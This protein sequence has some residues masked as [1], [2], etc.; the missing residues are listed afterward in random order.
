MSGAALIGGGL[1]LFGILWLLK[2]LMSKMRQA[3]VAVLDQ[4]DKALEQDQKGSEQKVVELKKA[5]AEKEKD[6]EKQSEPGQVID[7]WKG[8]QAQAQGSAPASSDKHDNN[9]KAEAGDWRG[10]I[11]KDLDIDDPGH[12]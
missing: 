5:A 12:D 10:L 4:K 7:F 3:E 1:L 6:A 8:K 2:K 9:F 11:E